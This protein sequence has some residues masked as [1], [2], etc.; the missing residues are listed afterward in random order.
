MEKADKKE[1]KWARNIVK[2]H[3]NNT[4]KTKEL[5]DWVIASG[6]IE[7]AENAMY[8][9]RDMALEIL[10]KLPENE[11]RNSLEGL[12]YYTINRKK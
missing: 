3:N 12:V 5:I 8:K 11:F 4:K 6:G 10:H 1:R 2:K 9:Y 7:Y